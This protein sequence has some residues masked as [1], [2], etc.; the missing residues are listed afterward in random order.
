MTAL[1]QYHYHYVLHFYMCRKTYFLPCGSLYEAQPH[2]GVSLAIIL[3]PQPY[4]MTEFR[5]NV[6]E[7]QLFNDFSVLNMPNT[8]VFISQVA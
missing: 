6:S 2:F 5:E 3:Q 7:S 8:E 1:T 4:M